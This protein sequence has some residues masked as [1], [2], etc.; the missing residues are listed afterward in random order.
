MYW[1]VKIGLLDLPVEDCFDTL[2]SIVVK[3]LEDLALKKEV[4]IPAK[5]IIREPW[6]SKGIIKSL[7]KK[8]NFIANQ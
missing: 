4:C 5:H 6:M 8:I 3:I 1:V 2:N 7:R